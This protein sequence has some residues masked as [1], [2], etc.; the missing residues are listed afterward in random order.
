MMNQTK[1]KGLSSSEAAENLRK[2]GPDQIFKPAKVS[3]FGIARHEITGPIIL[4]LLQIKPP[5]TQLQL[6]MKSLVGKL[7]FV[8][9]FFQYLSL[10]W[11]F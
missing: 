4:L 9:L 3:F 11:E 1:N 6:A 8:A 7:V 2:F 10:F 5:K